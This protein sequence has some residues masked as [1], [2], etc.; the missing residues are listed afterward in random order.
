M[1]LAHNGHSQLADSNSGEAT[2]QWAFGGLSPLGRRVIEEM[3]RVG[4][5]VDVSH[6]SKGAILQSIGLSKAPVI[7]SHSSVRRSRTIP[8]TWTMRC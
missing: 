3:N 4:M 8:E 6:P 1:S 5:M 7:A 2:N